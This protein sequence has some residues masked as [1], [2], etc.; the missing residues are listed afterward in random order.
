MYCLPPNIKDMMCH[1]EIYGDWMHLQW[2]ENAVRKKLGTLKTL[3]FWIWSSMYFNVLQAIL[4]V[5][6]WFLICTFILCIL[7]Y[8]GFA[9][10][11]RPALTGLNGILLLFFS[12]CWIFKQ[13]PLK[14]AYLLHHICLS[15]I[16]LD[17][18]SV[19]LYLL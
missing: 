10:F 12:W 18:V 5:L 14:S 15:S 16:Q 1:I 2:N 19:Q 6:H 13:I 4:H 7:Q 8:T 11:G 17:K 3:E 9:I